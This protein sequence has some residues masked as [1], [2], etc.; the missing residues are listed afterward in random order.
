MKKLLVASIGLASLFIA[1]DG[2]DSSTITTHSSDKPTSDKAVL[3]KDGVFT[4]SRDGKEYKVVL[5]NG[6]YWFAE[7]LNYLDSAE[8]ENLKGNVWC[9]DNNQK[10][11]DKYGA[12]YSWSAALNTS[13]KYNSSEVANTYMQSDDVCPSGWT[14]P[15][16]AQWKKL[17]DYIEDKNKSEY[18]GVSL[19]SVKGWDEVDSVPS[20]TN[21]FGFNVLAAGRRNNDGGFLPDGKNAYFWTHNEVDATTATGVTVRHNKIYADH[22]EYYKDHGMSIRCLLKWTTGDW[23]LSSLEEPEIEGDIDSSYI[24]EI[25]M[26]YG[27]VKIDSKSYKTIEIGDMTWMAENM[28]YKTE[29]SWCYDDESN[30]CDKYGRLYNWESAQKVCPEGWK[31]PS[32]SELLKLVEFHE[33]KRFLRSTDGWKNGAAPGL[34]FW[35]FNVLPAGEYNSSSETF[36]DKTVTGYFWSSD[37]DSADSDMAYALS[38]PF[39][40]KP[41]VKTFEKQLAY[42]VRCVKE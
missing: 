41:E 21:R 17:F 12:L 4:D 23:N 35:G 6:D 18:N 22:G 24:E 11:C 38:V 13:S 27:S 15:T 9:Y 14:V 3:I 10:N 28:N 36:V 2:G 7:N 5:I 29:G 25:P 20:G 33:N 32:W 39:S 1:C 19:K 30:N 8:M 16:Y 26:E 34:N 31:L 40:D 42:S 37:E